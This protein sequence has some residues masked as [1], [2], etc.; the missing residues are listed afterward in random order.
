[1]WS[2][3]VLENAHF[4]INLICGLVFFATFWLYFDAWG[5]KKNHKELI[6][7]LG[8]LL[9]A[10][11]FLIRATQVESSILMIPFAMEI[12][13]ITGFL[14]SITRIGGY[15]LIILSLI[16][17]PLQKA[18][19][20][21]EVPVNFSLIAL[22]SVFLMVV[23]PILAS[24]A[25]FMYLRLTIF[26]LESHLKKVSLAFFALSIAEFLSL[27]SSLRETQN[28]D[29][30]KLV[31]PLGIVWILEHVF[32]LLSAFILGKWVF[33]YLLKRFQ[34]QLFMIFTSSIL[35][36]FLVT[37]MSFTFL[38]LKNLEDETLSRFETDVKVLNMTI[39][40][41]K[42]QSLSDAQLIAQNNQVQKAIKEGNRRELADTLENFLLSKKQSFLMVVNESGQVLA[43]GEDKEK[44]GDILTADLLVK[45]ALSGESNA[46]VMAKEAVLAPEV[47]LRAAVPVKSEDKIIG[48]VITGTIIDNAFVDGMKKAT[49]LWLKSAFG[50]HAFGF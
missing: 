14:F 41:K 29:L 24:I 30:Y 13:K 45:K 2:Q 39:E 17:E 10:I 43:K 20:K 32:L 40:T 21:T 33:G 22:P 4:A 31:A 35:V 49:G 26:G 9:L 38:L 19:V 37:T 46:A 44:Y 50:D 8:F 47:S 11:S 16:I 27:A 12:E 28:I 6:R 15:L 23:N 18:P 34:T 48:A 36:I 1:M 25:G 3:F 5:E 42:E 7:F